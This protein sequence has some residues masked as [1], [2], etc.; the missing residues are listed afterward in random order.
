MRG[1]FTLVTTETFLNYLPN[2]S[3][4]MPKVDRSS[5]KKVPSTR[6]KD[7]YEPLISALGPFLKQGWTAVDTSNSADPIQDVFM[8]HCIKPDI[9]IYSDQPASN[10][11]LCR[12]S[13]MECFIEVKATGIHE[14]FGKNI[15]DLEKRGG[16][17]RD[18]R[19][20]LA[21][22]FAAMQAAQ[23]RT[24]SFGV[25]V[26][27]DT[28]RL[29]R[30]TRSGMTI[31][32]SFKYAENTHLQTFFWRL[33]HAKA[34]ERGTD[35]TFEYVPKGDQPHARGLLNAEDAR[36]YRVSVDGQ[37]YFVVNA[38]TRSHLYP[39]GRGTRCFVAVRSATNQKCLLKDTWR[40]DTYH[41]EGEVY[42][43]LHSHKVPNIPGVLHCGD[44][45]LG[46]E[47]H[48][49]GYPPDG[50]WRKPAN[51]TI[52]QH[53]HYRIVFDVVGEPLSEFKSTHNLVSCVRDAFKAHHIACT[54]AKVEHRDI[55]VGNILAVEREGIYRGL[56]IDWELARLE[57]DETSRAY[58]RTGTR[59]FMAA[60]LFDDPPPTRNAGDDIES[61]VLLLFWI[62][63]VYAPNKST[64]QQRASFLKKFEDPESKKDLILGYRQNAQRLGLETPEFSACLMRIGR[65]YMHRYDLPDLPD[66]RA[67]VE[68]LEAQQLA[69]RSHD[70]L[71]DIFKT[72][73]A[74]TVWKTTKDRA[75][76]NPI[77]LE[78]AVERKRKT[79]D[80]EYAIVDRN[81][82]QRG[83]E[84]GSEVVDSS[85]SSEEPES[86]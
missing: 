64:S 27:G 25:V 17:A 42:K 86:G 23:H 77:A 51:A 4:N 84:H 52:R 49:C 55:S 7:M 60:R 66:G 48:K 32:K 65:Q 78:E 39:V 20:Q 50:G 35:V 1:K 61:F 26:V 5:F 14:S 37:E 74:N 57:G 18:T 85:G 9:T 80:T 13:D 36:M 73:L 31:T 75:R 16:F 79:D 46:D 76:E 30:H 69:L 58:E 70:W 40:L 54:V 62:A 67:E 6:E 45:G 59:Q 47:G 28:C 53:I 22:Y 83:G 38:F 10:G 72:D 82:R 29:L 41:P 8:G 24:H 34:E 12:A 71:L 33:S 43:K 21:T 15:A 63:I 81:K 56:L 19:G 68:E 3:T 44:V 2:P 11:N